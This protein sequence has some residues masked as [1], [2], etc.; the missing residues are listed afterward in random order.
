LTNEKIFIEIEVNHYEYAKTTQ[1]GGVIISKLKVTPAPLRKNV[2]LPATL[3]RNSFI[4]YTYE[5]S[6]NNTQI[7]MTTILCLMFL[8]QIIH[9]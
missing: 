3:E 4:P 2:Q 9:L 1:S 7:T 8:E 5:V 6:T